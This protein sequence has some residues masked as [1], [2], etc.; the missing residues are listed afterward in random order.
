MCMYVQVDPMRAK[1]H[2]HAC[3]VIN[4][5][6]YIMGGFGSR[7]WHAPTFLSTTEVYDPRAGWRP[8]PDMGIPRASACSGVLDGTIYVLCGREV[9]CMQSPLHTY[10]VVASS[11]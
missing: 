8:G 9:V 2:S 7:A 11:S 6:M 1:R 5:E 3:E 10:S 4:D